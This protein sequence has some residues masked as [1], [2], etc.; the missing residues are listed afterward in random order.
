M[1]MNKFI[2]I[3]KIEIL[4]NIVRASSAMKH[5][6]VD[7]VISNIDAYSSKETGNCSAIT[8]SLAQKIT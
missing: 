7:L 5:G 6:V 3:K 4:P 2:P 8:S 1:L